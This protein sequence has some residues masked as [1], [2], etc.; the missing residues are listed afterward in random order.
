MTST[1]APADHPAG[2]SSHVTAC[3]A[4]AIGCA[5][6]NLAELG[7]FVLARTAITVGDGYLADGTVT[8][9]CDERPRA[10]AALGYW[11]V[12]GLDAL[13]AVGEQVAR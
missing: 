6:E 5:Q 3:R 11:L 8:C 12:L 2:E 1:K 10:M 4:H 13:D 9:Y 7:G